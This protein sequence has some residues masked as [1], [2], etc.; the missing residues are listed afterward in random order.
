MELF[1]TNLNMADRYGLSSIMSGNMPAQS[2]GI[3]AG[4]MLDKITGLTQQSNHSIISNY[5]SS[6]KEVLRITFMFY[7]HMWKQPQDVL[8]SNSLFGQG[9]A[10]MFVNDKLAS[11]YRDMNVVGIPGEFKRFEITLDNAFGYTP[12]QRRATALELLKTVDPKTGEPLLSA[13]IVRRL[14]LIGSTGYLMEPQVT[15]MF[16][17]EEFKKMMGAFPSMDPDQKQSMIKMLEMLGGGQPGGQPPVPQN[18]SPQ[19]LPTVG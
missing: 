16:Q 7:H 6:V 1:A 17:T 11:V 8:G 12:E 5:L 2:S 13:D 18:P 14:F 9:R 15:P 3:R 4:E 10:P 19:Q